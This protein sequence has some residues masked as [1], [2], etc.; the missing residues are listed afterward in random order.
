MKGKLAAALRDLND[1]AEAKH[2][3]AQR[4]TLARGLRIDVLVNSGN[5]YLQI[6][7]TG[8]WP[9]DAEWRTVLR[10]FAY[11]PPV[12]TPIRKSHDGRKF[13]SAQWPTPQRLILD[14]PYRSDHDDAT[15]IEE[16]N[17]SASANDAR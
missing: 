6:S 10:D 1:A 2:G 14:V 17:G 12:I 4:A 9:S 7:R 13:L 11:T 15:P 3:Y 8:E 5:T 16:T